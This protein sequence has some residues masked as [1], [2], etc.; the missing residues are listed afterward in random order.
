[1]TSHGWDFDR[2][3]RTQAVDVCREHLGARWRLAILLNPELEQRIAAKVE[4]G[5]YES[6]DEVIEK[7]LELLEARDRAPEAPAG[8]D[9]RPIWEVVSEI[10]RSVPEEAWEGVPTD[11]SKNLDHY[12][13]GVPKASE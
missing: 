8:K 2:I 1:M 12:L 3:L 5:Q 7:S 6:A 10:G 4:S 11:L 9:D 13:Y